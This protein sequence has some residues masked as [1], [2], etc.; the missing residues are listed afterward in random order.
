MKSTTSSRR[1]LLFATA[2]A[3]AL[4]ETGCRRTGGVNL[5]AP[6]TARPAEPVDPGIRT[7]EDLIAAMRERYAG[8]WYS[9]LTFV[10]TSTYYRP[11]GSVLRSET[12]P[13]SVMLPGR[14]RIDIGNP[15]VG[16][17]VI[18]A[19]DTI[20]QFQQRRLTRREPGNN[21]LQVLGFDVYHLPP[22]RTAEILSSLGYGL[23][24]M[25]RTNHEG[26]EYYVVGAR[27]GDLRRKQFWIDADR[28]VLW[29]ILEP[30]LPTD[31]VNT[32]EIRFHDYKQH[33][34]GWVAE[35]VDYLRNGSRYFFQKYADV[36]TDVEIDPAL[37]DPR[38]FTTAKHW[39]RPPAAGTRR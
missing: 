33:G 20:Y 31:T 38:Q 36:R 13:E 27:Q 23:S 8:K 26:R 37:F 6:D 9:T 29:R 22:G 18:Y 4:T 39:Y 12:W 2:A 19:N 1:R 32:R 25:Y 3:L 16:N 7:T 34:G 24:S 11:D 10:Q 14:L 28:L 30:W 21:P 15:S 17:A 35:E 5:P